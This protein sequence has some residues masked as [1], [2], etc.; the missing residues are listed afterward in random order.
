[1]DSCTYLLLLSKTLDLTTVYKHLR[2]MRPH[3]LHHRRLLLRICMPR[4]FKITL[5]HVKSM[6]LELSTGLARTILLPLEGVCMQLGTLRSRRLLHAAL[7]RLSLHVDHFVEPWPSVFGAGDLK[8]WAETPI[9]RWFGQEI[10]R[11]TPEIP[12]RSERFMPYV[13]G[14]GPGMWPAIPPDL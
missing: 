5:N 11:R 10:L 9:S 13:L 6:H 2:S 7:A 4:S 12:A 14:F 8:S 3:R 1:M